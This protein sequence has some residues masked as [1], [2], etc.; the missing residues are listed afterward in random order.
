VHDPRTRQLGLERQGAELAGDRLAERAA[1]VRD[2]RLDAGVVG[3]LGWVAQ[4]STLPRT[5]T[6]G[7]SSRSRAMVSA[8]Q[9]PNSA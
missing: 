9:A 3:R 8:G 7:W 4:R 1:A 5:Q 6:A 2:R